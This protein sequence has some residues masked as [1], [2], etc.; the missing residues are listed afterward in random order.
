MRELHSSSRGEEDDVRR[1]LLFVIAVALPAMGMSVAL[2][3][4]A[5]AAKAATTITATVSADT[6]REGQA[7]TIS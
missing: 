3:A 2:P 1:Q 4:A 6:V 5:S 7:I